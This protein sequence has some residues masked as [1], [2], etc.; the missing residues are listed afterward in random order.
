MNVDE[1]RVLESWFAVER[2]ESDWLAGELWCQEV[3]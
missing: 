2:V 3:V 1:L